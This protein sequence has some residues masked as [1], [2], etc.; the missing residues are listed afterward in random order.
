MITETK[1]GHYSGVTEAKTG[2]YSGVTETKTGH[3]SGVTEAKTGHYSG[4]TE[5]KTGHY[6]GVTETKTGHYSGVLHGYEMVERASLSRPYRLGT[7]RRPN[8][9]GSP[10]LPANGG[11]VPA[12]RAT[13]LDTEKQL[14][15][16]ERKTIKQWSHEQKTDREVYF[17]KLALHR[18]LLG[19]VHRIW[20][21]HAAAGNDKAAIKWEKQWLQL[22]NCQAE[23]IGYRADCCK[24]FTAPIAVPIGCNHRLCPLCCNRRGEKARKRMRTMFDRLTHPA[25]ITL[26]IPNKASIRKHDYTLFRQRV[27]KFIAQRKSWIKGGVYAMETTYNRAHGTWH[28]HVHI[29]A[30]LGAALPQKKD[31]VTLAGQRVYTFTAMKM[32]LEFD[33][34]R[35]WTGKRWGM[36]P[37]TDASAQMVAGDVYT[38]EEWVRAARAMKTREF[39]PGIGWR[40]IAGI[41]ASEMKMRKEWNAENRRV[42][43]IR[44]VNDRERAA[45]EVLKYITKSADFSD[46]PAAV[47]QFSDAVKGARLIQTFGSWY[48]V[49]IECEANGPDWG[50][51]SCTCGVNVWKRMGVFYR[52]DVEMDTQG[53]WRLK[54]PHDYNSLGTVPRPTIRALDIRE[55]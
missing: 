4:V 38:F 29:L 34:L 28:V 19:T 45:R 50:E 48:G 32:R 16:T 52:R 2:H 18:Q 1:T 53:R 23:W 33:W 43:D 35:L 26:T 44:A 3:Y 24:G 12:Q 22:H 6:S 10:S 55:G 11:T 15:T 31:F 21:D 36:K 41:S 5:A 14:E 37:R 54:L 17:Q 40:D 25:L 42:I 9:Q 47:E 49:K 30:D 27:R 13:S 20:Q 8:L 46:I 51:L 7:R 39:V